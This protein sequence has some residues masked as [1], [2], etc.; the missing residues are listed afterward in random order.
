MRSEFS[1]WFEQYELNIEYAA[2]QIAL[3]G[4]QLGLKQRQTEVDE[5][6]AVAE[7]LD[8]MYVREKRKNDE[9]QRRVDDL[10]KRVS[11]SLAVLIDYH[12]GAYID[13]RT[14]VDDLEQALK[15]GSDGS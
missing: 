15:G 5:Y 14:L 10:G 2:E 9:L 11:G 12:S 3:D 6:K 7:N 4:Y 8:E 13:M 1:K